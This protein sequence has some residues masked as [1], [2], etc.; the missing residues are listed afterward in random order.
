M[1]DGQGNATYT[2]VLH[3]EL[4]RHD[5]QLAQGFAARDVE[6]A[7]ESLAV[8]RDRLQAQAC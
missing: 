2:G 5:A 6:Q 3:E 8:L 1:I 4:Q 7:A